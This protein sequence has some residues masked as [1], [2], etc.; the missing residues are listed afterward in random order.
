MAL[1]GMAEAGSVFAHEEA[2]LGEPIYFL[3]HVPK[4][5][6]QTVNGHVR[7]YAPPGG[8]F[9]PPK[10]RGMARWIGPAYDV[11]DMPEPEKLR[12]VTGHWIAR[13]LE[14]RFD[15][16]EIRRTVLLRD[17]LSHAISYYNFRMMRYRAVG[18]G[19]YEFDVAYRAA[20]RNPICHFLLHRYFEIPWLRLCAMSA[21]DKY[22]LLN[23]FFGG[24]WFTADYRRCD[25]LIV[26][27]AEALGMPK[28][29]V[30]KNTSTEWQRRV[31]W[32]P[33]TADDLSEAQRSRIIEDNILDQL[34]WE[35][36][37][38]AGHD[39]A[40]V[41]PRPLPRKAGNAFLTNEAL[42]PWFQV[43]RRWKRA[44]G[45][46]PAADEGGVGVHRVS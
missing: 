2:G 8:Y 1:S 12:V 22:D 35:N 25:D 27:L 15:N 13:S 38:E 17:P 5:A 43:Q 44:T 19:A 7:A 30:R 20:A 39:T 40:R 11:R 9:R 16:R 14:R 4:C 23:R 28:K 32:K 41:S 24:F 42:R 37:R 45:A 31:D 33:L 36:W 46:I 3:L 34:L 29:A 10:R 6:G 26:S 21:E 18:Q